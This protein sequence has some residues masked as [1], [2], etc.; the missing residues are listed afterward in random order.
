MDCKTNADSIRVL[1]EQIIKKEKVIIRLK[2][3]RI[4]EL[5]PEVLGKVFH[6]NVTLRGTFGRLHK[7]SHN[8]L[9]VCCHWFEVASQTPEVWS[10]WG[11][12]P[13]DWARWYCRSGT[14]PLDLVLGDDDYKAK[15]FNINLRNALQDRA[16]RDTIRRVHLT[17]EDS[18]FLGSITTPLT[19]NS[20]ELRSDSIESFV[21]RDESDMS[22]D[23]SAFFAHYRFP[24]LRRLDLTGC[25]V[26]SRDG[27]T[28]RTCALTTL[29]LDLCFPSFTPTTSELLSILASNPALQ[30][31]A[32]HRR[33][34]PDDGGGKSSSRVQL[35]HLKGLEL[36]GELQHIIGLLHYLDLP[37]N[38]EELDLSLDDCDTTDISLVIGS[39]LRDLLQRRDRPQNG[40]KVSASFRYHASQACDITLHVGNAEGID[41]SVPGQAREDMFATISVE[42]D[43]IPDRNALER[44]TLDL[45]THIPR[46]E[47]VYFETY[48][49]PIA[50]ED[51][52]TQFPNL[53]A[54]SFD[55][56]PLSEAFPSSLVE[57]GKILPSLWNA[58]Y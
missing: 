23:V 13:K 28:S 37:R 55:A 50:T 18:R 1:D 30:K 40:L 35:R 44:A 7:R 41:F 54:L 26:S 29:K 2:R 8:F 33:G 39:Y 57:D 51:A 58:S 48:D 21:L 49:N 38:L 32:L 36:V 46:K 31:V 15:Y 24:K 53:R 42:L 17:A 56:I 6:Q 11:N 45:I 5:P 9:L 47:V 16:T 43:E 34:V 4:S 14:A 10:F 22:V 12:A 3:S 25:A 20:E 52:Y 19:S 27:L